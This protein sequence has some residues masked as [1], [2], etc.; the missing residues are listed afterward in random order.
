MKCVNIYFVKMDMDTVTF[1][2]Y[3]YTKGG[4]KLNEND[5][6]TVYIL[7]E[8][9]GADNSMSQINIIEKCKNFLINELGLEV[10]D[11]SF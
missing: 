7:I 10:Q 4:V 3:P 1:R 5:S 9:A 8:S 2:V 6:I 11:K